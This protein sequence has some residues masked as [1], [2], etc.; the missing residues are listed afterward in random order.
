MTFVFSADGH[1]VEPSDLFSEGLPQSLRRFGLRSELQDEFILSLAG[2]KVLSKTPMHRGAPKLGPDG[3]PF[4]RQRLME[5][6]TGTLDCPLEDVVNGLL[7][8]VTAHLQGAEFEDD[9]TILGIER[10]A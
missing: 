10:T 3:E 1:V 9:F 4:G 8:R 5:Y 2:D 6:F 7:A